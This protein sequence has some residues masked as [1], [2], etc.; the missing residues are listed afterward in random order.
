MD[1]TF[2]DKKRTICPKKPCY[3]IAQEEGCRKYNLNY[4]SACTLWILFLKNHYTSG[5]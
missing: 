5:E 3:A 1:Y 4:I 2:F